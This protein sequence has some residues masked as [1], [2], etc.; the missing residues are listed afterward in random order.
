MLASGAPSG[1]ALGWKVED[2]QVAGTKTRQLSHRGSPMGGSASV[3]IYPERGLAIAATTNVSHVKGIAPLGPK[4][5]EAFA[6]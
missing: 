6:R 1:F 4:I 5:A 3:W 2:V